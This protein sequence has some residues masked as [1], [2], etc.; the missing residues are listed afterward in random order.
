[1]PTRDSYG[2]GHAYNLPGITE[3]TL[4]N[5]GVRNNV[6]Q[7]HV[8]DPDEDLSVAGRMFRPSGWTYDTSAG[9][10]Q[11]GGIVV[12]GSHASG[13]FIF[14]RA[15]EKCR[16]N[17]EMTGGG[18]TLIPGAGFSTSTEDFKELGD[19]KSD[20]LLRSWAFCG[21]LILSVQS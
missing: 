15:G 17:Y 10:S 5:W 11:G 14:R 13:H 8:H 19:P 18:L 21:P 7:R 3:R 4:L 12:G 9:T 6:R 16:V 20:A 2:I 1:M